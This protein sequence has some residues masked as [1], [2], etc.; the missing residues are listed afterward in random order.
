M[1]ATVLGG[2]ILASVL[3]YAGWDHFGLA[4]SV[5]EL[6]S[7]RTLSVSGQGLVSAVPDILQTTIGVETED[8]SLSAALAANNV[9]LNAVLAQLDMLGIDEKDVQTVDFFITETRDRDGNLT[10]FRVVDNLS[11]TLR[12]LDTAGKVLDQ[13]IQ[14]G[15]N[16]VFNIQLGISDTA[17]LQSSARALAV[18][19]ARTKAQ[20]LAEAAG[21]FLGNP[22]TLVESGGFQPTSG[23]RA[24]SLEF[25]VG[26][27][28]AAGQL[29]VSV[30]VSITYEMF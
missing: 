5:A 13:L 15:A 10:G 2:I 28:I 20:E 23:A 1:V 11:L 22:L 14:A 19:N 24:A 29:S 18:K 27:P 25:D 21:M 9:R 4:Q 8:V 16:R 7:P 26:V 12:D 17:A 6:G 3:V 30:N